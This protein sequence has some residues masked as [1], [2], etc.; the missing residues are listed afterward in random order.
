MCS[1]HDAANMFDL[2]VQFRGRSLHWGEALVAGRDG[3]RFPPRFTRTC[4]IEPRG[5]LLIFGLMWVTL[6]RKCG[7]FLH[8][9]RALKWPQTHIQVWA[10]TNHS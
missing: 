10:R 7:D 6:A 9:T 8:G 3:S 4:P 5:T 2:G 1:D